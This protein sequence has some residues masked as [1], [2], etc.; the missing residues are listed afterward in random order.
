MG[1]RGPAH[2]PPR[3]WAGPRRLP[4]LGG[5]AALGAVALL[6]ASSGFSV[7]SAAPPRPP[8]PLTTPPRTAPSEPPPPS[9]PP[10]PRP[11]AGGGGAAC[12]GRRACHE[13]LADSGCVWCA[14]ANLSDVKRH[15]GVC[16]PA[17][18]AGECADVEDVGCSPVLLAALPARMRVVHVGIQKGGP[19]ALLQLHLALVYW[20]FRTSLDTRRKTQEK[21]G[22]VLPFF[23]EAYR[24]ELSRA[25]PI[26]WHKDFAEWLTTGEDGD[27]FV[28]TET[29]SCKP[30]LVYHQGR[31]R[32]LQWHLTVWPRKKRDDCTV[33]GHTH[34]IAERYM[35]VSALAVLFPYISPHILRRAEELR[36]VPK[37]QLVMYDS[38][39]GVGVDPDIE[40]RG[41]KNGYGHHG[42]AL[43][44]SD[45]LPAGAKGYEVRKAKGFRPEELYRKYAEAKVCID[46]RMPGAERFVYEAALFGC[47]II[48]D[49]ALN[50]AE[51]RD[52]PIPER[53]RVPAGDL[54]ELNIRKDE[55]LR[56]HATL[57]GEF[58]PLRAH[59]R[60]QRHNFRR[61][62]RQ[63]FSAQVHAVA[64]VGPGDA[65]QALGWVLAWAF[66]V[67]FATL[68]LLICS[69]AQLP[70]DTAPW[71]LL[72]TRTLLSAVKFTQGAACP[73]G[74]PAVFNTAVAATA[75][76]ARY[77]AFCAAI[78]DVP[79]SAELVRVAA[80]SIA[81]SGA[82]AT[83]VAGGS[84][85]VASA[86]RPGEACARRLQHSEAANAAGE[87]VGACRAADARYRDNIPLLVATPQHRSDRDAQ[88]MAALAFLC[89]H[90]V[91]ADPVVQ[92][93][94]A[95]DMRC[96]AR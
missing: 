73:E 64:A 94:L 72:R 78:R 38:D 92:A 34:Y 17:Q 15:S 83:A 21:G 27:V 7:P 55:L 60:A 46:L 19:E 53:F 20:G 61:H 67:P 31:G 65:A 81:L 18:Q 57:V 32:Q 90:P 47:G 63:Y 29:W 95:E 52:L 84:V 40:A 87:S 43:Q 48:S 39:A 14:Q 42:P 12:A 75:Q 1:T 45:L 74:A 33:A 58:E 86:G 37:K 71:R 4:L 89:R 16:I 68:E 77:V 56:D 70:L 62:V 2:R 8:P 30:G 24:E 41:A 59:V 11:R 36:G 25:P 26:R 88:W 44:D 85:V 79:A 28:A 54:R 51:P 9:P 69:G 3:S 80:T 96:T 82:A 91:Y 22:E 76:R 13:C 50:G 23:K 6:S 5:A 93:A 49:R 66:F 10:Q 35:Q